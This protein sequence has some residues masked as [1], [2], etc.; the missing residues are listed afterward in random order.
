MKK[1]FVSFIAGVITLSTLSLM[2]VSAA[3]VP[4]LYFKSGENTDIIKVSSEDVAGGDVTVRIGMYIDDN[5]N[6]IAN[7]LLKWKSDSDYV[8]LGNL[9]S[10]LVEINEETTYSLSDGTSFTTKT[11]PTC[12]GEIKNDMY[13]FQGTFTIPDKP[14][15]I[16]GRSETAYAAMYQSEIKYAA[17]WLDGDSDA[18]MISDFDAVISQG[19]PDGFY[20]I[21]Y[22][23]PEVNDI[24]SVTSEEWKKITYG[25]YYSNSKDF[26]PEVKSITIQVGEPVTIG[27]LNGDGKIDS[28]DASLV[29]GAYA[30]F[31]SGKGYNLEESQI[32]AADVN[33]DGIIDSSD[34]SRILEYY[35]K[36][37]SG[38]EDSFD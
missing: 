20:K 11:V 16:T 2:Q 36:V 5:T 24:S 21:Y 8:T 31:S 26:L 25:T 7:L 34:S 19:T 33:H 37:S 35:A 15:S 38:K 3:D 18:Y 30:S 32:K 12:F 14:D 10:P 27:D 1:L 13:S 6:D 28:F 9:L 17:K 29:L 4:V 22:V 23:S